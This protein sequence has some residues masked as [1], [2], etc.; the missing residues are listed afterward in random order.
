MTSFGCVALPLTVRAFFKP[1]LDA[2]TIPE[3]SYV[4]Q[5]CTPRGVKSGSSSCSGK[6]TSGMGWQKPTKITLARLYRGCPHGGWGIHYAGCARVLRCA[7]VP[8]HRSTLTSLIQ[9]VC[10]LTLSIFTEKSSGLERGLDRF[11][12]RPGRQNDPETFGRSTLPRTIIIYITDPF[13]PGPRNRTVTSVNI[14]W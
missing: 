6:E 5:A 8:S 12:P 3:F 11:H 14:T 1:V 13:P 4:C 10:G 7:P 2:V 9:A